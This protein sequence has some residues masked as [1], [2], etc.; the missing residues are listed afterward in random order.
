MSVRA[1][2]CLV[3]LVVVVVL[4][5]VVWKLPE[6]SSGLAV[7]VPIGPYRAAGLPIRAG[8]LLLL[9]A[10]GACD[11]TGSCADCPPVVVGMMNQGLQ[12]GGGADKHLL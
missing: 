11:M 4:V 12:T 7:E 8:L 1:P 5:V 9:D 10:T 3:L 2:T 6:A